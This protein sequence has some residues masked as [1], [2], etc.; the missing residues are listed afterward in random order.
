MGKGKTFFTY[1][2]TYLMLEIRMIS[3]RDSTAAAQLSICAGFLAQ[4]LSAGPEHFQPKTSRSGAAT[5]RSKIGEKTRLL[6]TSESEFGATKFAI[7]NVTVDFLYF[8]K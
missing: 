2:R 8:D 7:G 4:G 5:Q 3:I 6:I 1:T